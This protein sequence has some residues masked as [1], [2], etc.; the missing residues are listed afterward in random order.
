MFCNV[1]VKNKK[2][3]YK[4]VSDKELLEDVSFDREICPRSVEGDFLVSLIDKKAYN[5]QSSME[6]IEC[7]EINEFLERLI[8]EGRVKIFSNN[9]MMVYLTPIGRIVAYGEWC[10]R[11]REIKNLMK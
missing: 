4:M 10:L 8:K 1:D 3:V 2:L 6:F 11:R 7:P 5:K 9:P